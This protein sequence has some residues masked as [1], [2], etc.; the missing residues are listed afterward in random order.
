MPEV[1]IRTHI[2]NI[3]PTKDS[4]NRRATQYAN[5]ITQTLRQLGAKE[6]YIDVVEERM[7]MKKAPAVISWWIDDTH[8][9]FKY[10]KMTKF[11]DNMLVAWKVIERHAYLVESGE[12]PMSEFLNIFKEDKD[13]DDQRTKAREF[14]GLD[15]NHVDLESINKQY[16]ILAKSL[17]PDMPG[18][19]L[20]KFKELN[21]HH[22]ILKRE[23]E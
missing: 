21:V 22:K 16:K 20:E 6:D 10:D 3:T 4:F 12:M 17:H 8:C 2:Y 14:F 7:A 18:G 11:V 13:V 1:K 23:L 15:E 5:F 19:D 9:N